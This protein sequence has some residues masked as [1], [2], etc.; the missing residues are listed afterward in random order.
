[1]NNIILVIIMLTVLL[2]TLYPLFADALN[3][4]KIS[5]G[6]PYF[7]F[8]FVPFMA[9]LCIFMAMGPLALWKKTNMMQMWSLLKHPLTISLVIAA[10]F[11]LVYGM[12]IVSVPRLPCLLR[13]G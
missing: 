6:P 7:N 4:G 2:G 1:M 8:F 10:I 12:A 13:P 5:V 9:L 3:L 11:P